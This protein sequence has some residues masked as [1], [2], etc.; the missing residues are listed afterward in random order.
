MFLVTHV[1]GT[2]DGR[3]MRPRGEN[4]TE[5]FGKFAGKI[6]GKRVSYRRL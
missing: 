6:Q 4:F 5:S 2:C 1:T 3:L